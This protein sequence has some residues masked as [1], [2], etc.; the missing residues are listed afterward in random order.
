M[1]RQKSNAGAKAGVGAAAERGVR[2]GLQR[3][4]ELM[5]LA[6][7]AAHSRDLPEFLSHCLRARSAD[8][9]ARLVR[10][11]GDS[12]AGGG[13][14]SGEADY[15]RSRPGSEEIVEKARS[16][17]AGARN[18]CG[19]LRPRMPGTEECE[20]VVVP[21]RA[22]DG[23]ALGAICVYGA[24]PDDCQRREKTFA[25]AGQPR[26]AIAGKFPALFA[27]RAIEA[28]VGAGY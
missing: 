11:S 4:A 18:C 23:E 17:P 1:R 24:R 21:V 6:T 15:R 16:R 25:R 10:G 5:E 22:S 7:E 14:R 28:A 20:L 26:G 12:W 13:T 9:S 2:P 8:A 19:Q 3:A 27:T